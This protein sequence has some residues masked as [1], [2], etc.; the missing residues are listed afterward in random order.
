MAQLA[1]LQSAVSGSKDALQAAVETMYALRPT[2][3]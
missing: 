1:Q 3:E 2:E